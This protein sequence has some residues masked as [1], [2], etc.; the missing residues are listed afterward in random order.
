[1]TA[2]PVVSPNAKL[3]G[4]RLKVASLPIAVVT[5]LAGLA[6]LAGAPLFA[7]GP[8]HP[9]ANRPVASPGNA[10]WAAT[11]DDARKLAAGANKLV[12]VEFDGGPECGQCRRMGTLLYPAFDFEA[13]LIP[14]VPVKVLLDSAE[15]K[16]LAERYSI[17]QTPA[18]LITTPEG[19]LAFL[20]QGFTNAPEFYQHVH[21]DL[22]AYRKFAR[23]SEAQDIAGLS[24]Q[25]A[26]ETGAELYQRLDP[27][28]ALP[29]LKRAVS[30]PGGAPG[31]RDEA[32]EQLAAVQLELGQTAAA[33]ATTEALLKSTRDPGCRERAE[34][35]RAQLPL[36]EGKAELALKL[37]QKFVADHPKSVHA[38]Q[39]QQIID[40]LTGAPKSS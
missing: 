17:D 40:R 14:M 25:E 38:K 20:M 23:R 13:L 15:G 4:V 24:A 2:A 28:A 35:F 1:M 6:A 7:Q 27:G 26:L 29:R 22:D 10:V 33:R 12:F 39:V 18:V 11:S 3:S 37:L 30:A 36:H 16:E 31:L 32:R 34:I 9:D 19:R 5:G 8:V 21:A